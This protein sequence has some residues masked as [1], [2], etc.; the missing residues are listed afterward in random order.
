VDLA[1]AD[2][3]AVMPAPCGTR[4]PAQAGTPLAGYRILA[5]DDN[6]VNLQ[7]VSH[8]LGKLGAEVDLAEN[9][10]IA[11]HMFLAKPYALILMDCQM[12]EL[13]GYQAV[14]EIRH[15]ENSM[16]AAQG[17]KHTRMPIIALTAHALEGEREKC[18]ASG[19]DDFLTK[20]LRAAALRDKLVGWLA[21]QTGAAATP[22]ADACGDGVDAMQQMF[23]AKYPTLVQLFLDDTPPR[24]VALDAA[25]LARDAT[26]IADIAHTVAGSAAALGAAALADQCRAL[27]HVARN[28]QLDGVGAKHAA[29]GQ[30]FDSISIRLQAILALQA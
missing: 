17:S 23:G 8:M 11:V 7:V 10:R 5:V 18:I 28:G 9:G 22:E 1:R 13:D 4:Q 16:M 6:P 21:P 26:H 19:M 3:L 29:L 14:E 15:L 25:V 30:E 27:E 12:P 24:L 2:G 20:P